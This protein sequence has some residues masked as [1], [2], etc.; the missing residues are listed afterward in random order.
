MIQFFCL[1]ERLSQKAEIDEKTAKN[2]QQ[3]Q[4]TVSNIQPTLST[5]NQKQQTPST[6]TKAR[7]NDILFNA[8]N[9]N[10]A[11]KQHRE[12]ISTM[13]PLNSQLNKVSS[14]EKNSIENDTPQ[15]IPSNK[16]FKER[17]ED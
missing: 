15:I 10:R 3:K 4:S 13:I 14:Y 1:Q 12:N 5:S 17:L 8:K 6:L 2:E 9:T 16:S 11:S 7:T